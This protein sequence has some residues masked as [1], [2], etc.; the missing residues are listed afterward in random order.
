MVWVVEQAIGL[1]RT[2]TRQV[3]KV[4]SFVGIMGVSFLE[5][6]LQSVEGWSTNGSVMD[7][8]P[9]GMDPLLGTKVLTFSG[10]PQS[11]PS[12]LESEACK[13]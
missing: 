1:Q 11:P 2:R 5:P 4:V 6:T 13:N 9:N 3:V 8:L 12:S 7:G 10:F